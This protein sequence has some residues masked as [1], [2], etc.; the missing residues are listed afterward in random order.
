MHCACVPTLSAFAGAATE[1]SHN[2]R[3]RLFP[4]GTDASGESERSPE[5]GG[6]MGLL[7]AWLAYRAGTRRGRRDVAD[8]I[9]LDELLEECKNC[10]YLRAQHDDHGRCPRYD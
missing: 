7:G 10:G 1:P 8:E 2:R 3:C 4:W 6:C 5:T 9:E